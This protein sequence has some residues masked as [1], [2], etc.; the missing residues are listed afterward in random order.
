MVQSMNNMIIS[1]HDNS[2]HHALCF[3]KEVCKANIY[4]FLYLCHHQ[5]N[6][7]CGKQL[8]RDESYKLLWKVIIPL[9]WGTQQELKL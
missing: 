8:Q 5:E 9:Q 4:F 7:Y 1:N 6:Y 2:L 3:V